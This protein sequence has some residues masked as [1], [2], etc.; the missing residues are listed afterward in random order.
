MTEIE[1][2]K[3]GIERRSVIKGAAWSVPVIAAAVATPLAAASGPKAQL[4]FGGDCVLDVAGL[5]LGPGFEIVNSGTADWTGTIT[6][7][8]TF[9]LA[10]LIAAIARPV[11]RPIWIVGAI[12]DFETPASDFTTTNWSWPLLE[13]AATRSVTFSGTI[14]AGSR[15]FWG[16]PF[17]IL[18]ALNI[19]GINLLANVTHSATV[20][21]ISPS[22]SPS[23]A[24]GDVGTINWSLINGSC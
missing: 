10:G 11:V 4:A 13:R 5:S 18:G 6:F 16:R 24:A 22:P 14:P 3:N 8:E 20:T 17:S 21:S 9:A 19:P 1:T 7:T 2:T 23:I 15:A 12:G